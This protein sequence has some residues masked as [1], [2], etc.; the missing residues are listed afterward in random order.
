MGRKWLK[1]AVFAPEQMSAFLVFL[2][3]TLFSG[4][5]DKLHMLSNINNILCNLMW[6]LLII[7][8]NL[9]TSLVK[10]KIQDG[11]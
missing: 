10:T 3:F 6:F 8:A 4:I 9:M 5:Y 1:Y 11:G 2:Y 7:Y